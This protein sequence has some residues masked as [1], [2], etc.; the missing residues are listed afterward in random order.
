MQDLFGQCGGSGLGFGDEAMFCHRR[1]Q[2]LHVLWQYML[3]PQQQCV[4]ARRPQQ[5]QPGAERQAYP[6]ARVFA[7][8]CQQGLQ[9]V[10]Q[11]IAG[12]DRLHGL[13]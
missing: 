2:C 13:P 12:V 9:V 7:A 5:R 4:R 11:G 3:T 10:Q 1:K 8:A 6:H